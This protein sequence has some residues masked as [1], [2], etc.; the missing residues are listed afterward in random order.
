MGNLALKCSKKIV[1]GGN[2]ALGGW[3]ELVK[4]SKEK[5][6]KMG[7]MREIGGNLLIFVETGGN[8]V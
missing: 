2:R 1:C 3:G 7:E 5:C 4:A 8:L 6:R